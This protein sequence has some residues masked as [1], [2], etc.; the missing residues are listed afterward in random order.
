MVQRRALESPAARCVQI[1]TPNNNSVVP[2]PQLEE[3]EQG[4]QQQHDVDGR[5]TSING[6]GTL[7][8]RIAE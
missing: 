1:L 4:Q 7:Q 2:H 6:D 3:S 8:G 5:H